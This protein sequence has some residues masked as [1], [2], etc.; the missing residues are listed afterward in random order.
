MINS[1]NF[2]TSHHTLN[3]SLNLSIHLPDFAFT[4]S[5]YSSLHPCVLFLIAWQNYILSHFRSLMEKQTWD[6][7]EEERVSKQEL[8]SALLETACSLDEEKCVQQAKALFKQYVESNGTLRYEQHTTNIWFLS[9]FFYSGI[10]Q[11][12]WSSLYRKNNCLTFQLQ[13]V[14]WSFMYM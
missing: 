3:L 14:N 4:F 11:T 6:E 12:A 1:F 13:E 7:E 2:T 8:R 10:E 5:D 9:W